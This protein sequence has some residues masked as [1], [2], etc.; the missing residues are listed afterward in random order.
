[1]NKETI[2]KYNQ[3]HYEKNSEQLKENARVRRVEL[4]KQK[5]FG[6][7]LKEFAD[8]IQLAETNYLQSVVEETGVNPYK[9]A[10][11]YKKLRLDMDLSEQTRL[12]IH[13]NIPLKKALRQRLGQEHQVSELL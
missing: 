2:K 7:L 9:L 11:I 5:T 3:T 6:E 1:M 13:N 10:N 4:K 12:D 8:N